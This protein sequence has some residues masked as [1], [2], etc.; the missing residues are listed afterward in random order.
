M[1]AAK[2]FAGG[3]VGGIAGLLVGQPFDVL[4]IRAQT[5]WVQ[6]Q[7][8]ALSHAMEMLGKEGVLSLFKGVVP[9]MLGNGFQNAVL[10]FAYGTAMRAISPDGKVD[11]AS[12]AMVTIAGSIGG[13]C[14]SF[15]T[16]PVELL[17][18]RQQVDEKKTGLG[19]VSL[20]K[21]MVTAEG[22][23]GI[24][25]GLFATL[26]RDVP[27]YGFYFCSYEQIRRLYAGHAGCSLLEVPGSVDFLAGGV[28]GCLSWTVIYPIDV[29]KSRL[30]M[31]REGSVREGFFRCAKRI[32]STEGWRVFGKGLGLT[33]ARAFP[34]NATIF[35]FHGLTVKALNL[36]QE[37]YVSVKVGTG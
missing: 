28:G 31:E 20:V 12:L 11:E 13:F 35:Y 5:L 18:V 26:V 27:S 16:G 30:Q 15:V 1:D 33:V 29:V 21:S 22:F 19:T 25:R 10:F 2:D 3:T 24:Y 6:R 8:T 4:R 14:C 17:K 7:G 23:S 36:I 9:P 34:V 37:S 32:F